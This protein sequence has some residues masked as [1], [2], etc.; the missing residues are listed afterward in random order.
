MEITFLTLEQVRELH[1][2]AISKCSP[3]ESGRI[4]DGALLE[5]A[6]MA[7]QQT[8]DGEY[9]YPT[10]PGMAAAYLFGL[11]QN[12]AFENGNKR[13]AF[14]VCATFLLMNGFDLAMSNDEAFELTMRVVTHGISRQELIEHIARSM[15][16]AA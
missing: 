16:P 6:V 10:I 11:A 7:P 1:T 3:A 4:R 8:F 5:S 9:L 13:V 14:S 12:H 15:K 2:E